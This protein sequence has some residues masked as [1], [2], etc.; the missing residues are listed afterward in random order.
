MPPDYVV[1]L[2]DDEEEQDDDVMIDNRLPS[3]ICGTVQVQ[4]NFLTGEDKDDEVEDD[5]NAKQS[6]Q[7]QLLK[8]KRKNACLNY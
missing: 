3:D 5:D 7:S 4:T 2:A 8:M 6:K 1:L